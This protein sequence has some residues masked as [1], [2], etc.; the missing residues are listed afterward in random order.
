MHIVFLSGN[1]EGVSNKTGYSRRNLDGTPPQKEQPASPGPASPPA[2][3][4]PA[5]FIKQQPQQQRQ[6]QQQVQM[7]PQQQQPTVGNNNMGANAGG[8][9]MLRS[10]SPQ[11][12]QGNAVRGEMYQPLPIQQI[13]PQAP[14]MPFPPPPVTQMQPAQQQMYA[15]PPP[16]YGAGGGG[17]GQQ[18]APVQGQFAQAQYGRAEPNIPPPARPAVTNPTSLPPSPPFLV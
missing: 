10:M 4:L 14:R 5:G 15:P 18:Y 12:P 8:A 16:L 1:V 7:R 17:V 2:P 9:N 6:P 3:A 13:Q 11:R